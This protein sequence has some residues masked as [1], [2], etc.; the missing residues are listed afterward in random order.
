VTAVALIGTGIF[1]YVAIQGAALL[2]ELPVADIAII[3]EQL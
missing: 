2:L 3:G 1:P